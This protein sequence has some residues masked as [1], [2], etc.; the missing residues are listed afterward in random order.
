MKDEFKN[1][2]ARDR[3]FEKHPALW[4]TAFIQ[5]LRQKE[6]WHLQ[7]TER[8]ASGLSPNNSEKPDKVF[9]VRGYSGFKF[10]KSIR[11]F[12]AFKCPVYLLGIL[13]LLIF[14][15][16]KGGPFP[17]EQCLFPMVLRPRH[18]EEDD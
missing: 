12:S 3:V 6:A 5:V 16:T 11:L 2:F 9:K 13:E 7:P 4:G 14:C 8:E 18:T 17:I 10:F 1:E 15:R